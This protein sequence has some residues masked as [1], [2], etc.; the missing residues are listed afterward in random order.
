MRRRGLTQRMSFMS[1]APGFAQIRLDR[2]DIGSGGHAWPPWQSSTPPRHTV[3]AA[4]LHVR[5]GDPPSAARLYAG[6]ARSAPSL[7]E[8]DHLTR[9]AAQ[10][11]T[12]PMGGLL[13]L[14]AGRNRKVV[15]VRRRWR[16]HREAPRG[17]RDLTADLTADPA[18]HWRTSVVTAGL[19]LPGSEYETD[20]LGHA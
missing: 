14:L 7:P 3:A 17:T 8:R 11:F 1:A 19:S 2:A 20:S 13:T 9:Q 6:A 18:G 4:Y 12:A 5:D 15:A 16:K 10:A